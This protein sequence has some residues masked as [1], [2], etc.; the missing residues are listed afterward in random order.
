MLQ[1]VKHIHVKVS[2]DTL[3]CGLVE[4]NETSVPAVVGQTKCITF[5]GY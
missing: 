1:H 2:L 5:G 3:K 4:P